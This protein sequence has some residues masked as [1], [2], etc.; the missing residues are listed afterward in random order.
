MIAGGVIWAGL[1]LWL[2]IELGFLKGEPR[3]NAYGPDPRT[4][5]N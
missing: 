3:E 1:S 5:Q 4:A 2:L